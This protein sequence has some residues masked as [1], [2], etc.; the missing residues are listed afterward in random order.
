MPR[1]MAYPGPLSVL[2]MDNAKIHHDD[3]ILELADQ[4]GECMVVLPCI[5]QAICIFSICRGPN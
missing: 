4:F 3:A 2:V 1:C 5:I